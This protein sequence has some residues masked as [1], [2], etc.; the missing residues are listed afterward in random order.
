MSKLTV[1]GIIEATSGGFLPPG[2]T[3]AGLPSVCNSRLITRVTDD[4][5]GLW[6]DTGTKWYALNGECVNV[7]EYAS[8]AAAITDIGSNARTLI[9]PNSQTV[10]ANVT[11]P[12]TCTLF[13]TGSGQ[14]KVQV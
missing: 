4:V 8:F 10:A 9:I 11:V 14:N 12:S 2:Y 7:E 6:I 3:K 13:F 5:R 1:S